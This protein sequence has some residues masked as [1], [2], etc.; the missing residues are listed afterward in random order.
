V[1]RLAPKLTVAAALV[2]LTLSACSSSASS[3]P[4]PSATTRPSTS[5]SASATRTPTPTPSSSNTPTPTASATATATTSGSSAPV[6][7]TQFIISRFLYIPE[8]LKVK[9][10]ATVTVINQDPVHHTATGTATAGGIPFDTGTIEANATGQFTA[11]TTP[12]T[13][14]VICIFHPFM[15]G[16]L[17]VSP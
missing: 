3:K 9:P 8:N 7:G 11:P 10:G 1:P 13:Y 5:P 6:A 14:P 12:G 4:S 16:T 2:A 15:H 17:T